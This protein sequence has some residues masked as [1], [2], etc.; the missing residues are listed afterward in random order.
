[1]M[2][3]L[4][5]SMS[6]SS[7]S[8]SNRFLEFDVLIIFFPFQLYTQFGVSHNQSVVTSNVDLVDYCYVCGRVWPVCLSVDNFDLR[9][10]VCHFHLFP[11]FFWNIVFMILYQ[12]VASFVSQSEPKFSLCR[13]YSVCSL[14]YLSIDVSHY[15]RWNGMVSLKSHRRRCRSY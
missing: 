12:G 14:P 4:M 1:M 13:F 2:V 11:A 9:Y 3:S 7:S 5:V 6:S 15:Y 8:V 10:T